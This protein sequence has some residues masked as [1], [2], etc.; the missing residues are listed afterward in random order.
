M[1]QIVEKVKTHIYIDREAKEKAKHIFLKYG[2]SMSGA[3]NLFLQKVASSGKIPFP[4]K[5]P[6]A[7]TERVM[8]DIELD[9]NVED[10]SLEEMIVEAEAQ[11]T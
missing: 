4:L 2:L 5:V 11:K 10:T 9:K 7:V 8:E 6:N 1:A 3:I